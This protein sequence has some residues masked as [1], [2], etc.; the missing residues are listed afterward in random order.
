[1]H[2]Q[3]THSVQQSIPAMPEEHST[4]NPQLSRQPSFSSQLSRLYLAFPYQHPL[5][6]QKP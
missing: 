2:Y 1:M 3:A 6:S 5:T 4:Y